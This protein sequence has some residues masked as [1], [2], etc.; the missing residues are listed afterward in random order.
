MRTKKLILSLV[1]ITLS[2]SLSSCVVGKKIDFNPSTSSDSREVEIVSTLSG[3]IKEEKVFT[4]G[5]KEESEYVTTQ[6]GEFNLTV[7]YDFEGT[8]FEKDREINGSL[9]FTNVTASLTCSEALCSKR[10]GSN[11]S[12]I[13][14]NPFS[15]MEPIVTHE[16]SYTFTGTLLAGRSCQ[17]NTPVNSDDILSVSGKGYMTEDV[18]DILS[19]SSSATRVQENEFSSHIEVTNAISLLL[20]FI[21]DEGSYTNTSTSFKDTFIDTYKMDDVDISI[22]DRFAYDILSENSKTTQNIVMVTEE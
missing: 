4:F 7:E 10:D 6:P 22:S 3:H 13:T 8:V 18:S 21:Y 19:S 11:K 1:L 16:P 14:L 17:L 9:S 15:E 5:M 2:T 12:L 20:F